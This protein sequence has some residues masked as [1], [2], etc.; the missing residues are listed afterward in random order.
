METSKHLFKEIEK[1]EQLFSDG[2][3]R[4]AQKILRDVIKSSKNLENIPNKLRHKINSAISKSKYYDDISSFATNPKRNILIDEI[5][6]LVKNPNSDPRAHAHSIHDLQRKWQLLDTSGKSASKKQ[7]ENFN[8]LSN[9]AWES[10]ADY[11]E[12]I[13]QI[14]IDNA[15][16]RELIID[17]INTYVSNNKKNWP[18]LKKLVLFLK[19][20][21]QKWQQFAPVLE[22][23]IDDLKTKYLNARKP[24]NDEI[25]NQELKNKE[26]KEN[27]IL[28][29]NEIKNEDNNLNIKE[30]LNVK[31]EWQK[32]GPAGKKNDSFLWKKFNKSGDRFYE[33]KN[34][35][36][37][38]NIQKINILNKEL[39]DKTKTSNEVLAE[40]KLFESI[41][42]TDEYKIIK[43]NINKLVT[44]EKQTIKNEKLDSYKKIYDVL[45]NNSEIEKAPKIFV[46]KINES[47]LNKTSSLKDLN[48]L[49]VK[50]ELLA[51]IDS[52]KKDQEIRGKIQFELL[53]NK[54]NTKKNSENDLNSIIGYF[55]TNFSNQD[56]TKTHQNL[57]KRMCNCFEVLI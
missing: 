19:D 17:N 15:K 14:K 56:V 52:P 54:F 30:F 40:L 31:A 26:I 53:S 23:D 9:K 6:N 35:L 36:V 4:N 34:N 11:F 16:K 1:A 12:E 25:K 50:L 57:W 33:E 44:E 2:A 24:I 51:N 18:P 55:I 5:K 20:E 45:V 42:N 47:F 46:N 22:T 13:K 43:K 49:C 27:L 41:R 3:I 29:V 21:Y 32:I 48:Y 38:E 8:D 28:K 39:L 37:K 7:W 10:C